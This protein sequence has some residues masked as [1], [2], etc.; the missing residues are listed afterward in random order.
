MLYFVFTIDGDWK[1]Y[2][3]SDLSPEEREPDKKK[4]LALIGQEIEFVSSL[5]DG[6]F[7]HFI[8]TSPLARD[9][10]LQPEFISSWKEIEK[11]GGNVGIHCHEDEFPDDYYFND[12]ARMEMAIANICDGLTD[13][14]LKVKSYRGGYMT[15][16]EKIIPILEENEIF[17]D[18]SCDPGRYVTGKK[19]IVSDWRGAPE[20][21]YR[22]SYEDQR[23]PGNSNVIEVPLGIYIEK[24][25]IL[26]IIK[27]AK[28]LKK[29]KG[30]QIISVLAHSYDFQSKRMILKIKLALS[31]L[32]MYGKFVNAAQALELIEGA[33]NGR[34]EKTDR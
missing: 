19:G 21:Y 15:F 12:Q 27:K 17:I 8:H 18:F 26:S 3:R 13:K 28:V 6:K 25:A 7:I 31:I 9:F 4:M 22:L 2:F 33:D 20:N 14:G 29:R 23:K 11:K 24:Q 5:L 30:L 32:K 34:M 1:E 16:S 10:F